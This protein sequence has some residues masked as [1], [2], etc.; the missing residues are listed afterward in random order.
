MTEQK[1]KTK[2]EKMKENVVETKDK[3]TLEN[4]KDKSEVKKE[5][6]DTSKNEEKKDNKIE[7][8]KKKI[9]ENSNKDQK[10]KTNTP[11]K[12]FALSKSYNNHISKKQAM[13]ICAYVKGKKIDLAIEELNEVIKMKRAIPFKGEIPHR[14]GKGMMS[15][16]YPVKACKMFV[17]FLK[18]LKGNSI[19]N[20]LDIDNTIVSSAMANWAAR[21]LR[22]GNRKA[23]RTHVFLEAKEKKMR[24]NKENKK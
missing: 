21:P 11:K 24:N 20:G 13:Y 14:K 23:K 15:G 12:E 17:N 5:N 9:E 6:V 16:R 7:E 22:R 4:N 3:E 10:K 2:E 8:A 1:D 19:V 18:S